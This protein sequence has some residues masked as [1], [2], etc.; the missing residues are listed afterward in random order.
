MLRAI[1]ERVAFPVYEKVANRQYRL[2]G[3]YVALSQTFRLLD[4]DRQPDWRGYVFTLKPVWKPSERIPGSPSEPRGGQRP[5]R[6][7]DVAQR[8]RVEMAA[9]EAVRDHYE[10]M[11]YLVIFDH[12]E[13]LGWDCEAPR[14]DESLQLEVKGVSGPSLM[15]EL[16]PNEYRALKSSETY[17]VCVVNNALS[18]LRKVH[19]FAMRTD[20]ATL[21]DESG[22]ILQ[23]D[24]REGAILRSSS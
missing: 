21:A 4:P 9:M 23:I 15:V 11:N 7:Q 18:E 2:L 8:I 6:Q 22:K 20:M 13:N 1:Q 12:R 19:V 17:R 10:R 3:K 5:P 16:T 14:A 24:P